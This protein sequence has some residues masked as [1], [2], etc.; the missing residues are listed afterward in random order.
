VH[1]L[2]SIR[3]AV[4]REPELSKLIAAAYRHRFVL[5]FVPQALRR[6]TELLEGTQDLA[7]KEP[8]HRKY[9]DHQGKPHR[10]EAPNQALGALVEVIG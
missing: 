6:I 9:R 10:G 7:L 5:A 2:Q 8:G 3:H 4:E 1:R